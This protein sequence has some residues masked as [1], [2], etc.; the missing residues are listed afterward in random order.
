MSD[1][2]NK[3]ATRVEVYSDSAGK[4]HWRLI[5]KANIR[6]QSPQGYV[7]KQGCLIALKRVQSLMQDTN[8]IILS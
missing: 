6:A 5:S 2:L 3:Q 7:S 4:W 1:I 8:T